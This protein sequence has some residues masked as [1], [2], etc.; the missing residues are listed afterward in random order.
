M[1][2]REEGK[3]SRNEKEESLAR[4]FKLHARFSS[5][6]GGNVGEKRPSSA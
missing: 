4:E 6:F 3:N 5:G 1:K 2:Y